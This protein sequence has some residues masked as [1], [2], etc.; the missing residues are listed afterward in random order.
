MEISEVES[1]ATE[2]PERSTWRDRSGGALFLVT[3]AG[4]VIHIVV[5][6]PLW[7]TVPG[8]TLLAI[9][10]LSWL[11]VLTGSKL[12]EP[13]SIGLRAGAIATLGY[14]MTRVAVV[15]LFSLHTKPFVAWPHFGSAIVG[16]GASETAR[17]VAGGLFHL[18][19]G[20]A[21]AIAYTY[22]F[23]DRGPLAG[24]AFALVLECFMLG[25][26]PGWLKISDYAPFVF[27]SLTGH[28]FYG[29][30]IGVLARRW[31]R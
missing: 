10:V 31:S 7:L 1:S 25:L 28:L 15:H 20:L 17:W 21:F 22:W 14:D 3:G 27:V 11:N 30:T 24:I 2:G 26:Y 9:A 12:R 5:G 8:G 13:V 4:L 6:L 23:R 29:T 18:T 16:A 19:N